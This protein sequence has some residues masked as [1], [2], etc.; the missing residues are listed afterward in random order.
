MKD[1][2][3]TL[4]RRSPPTDPRKEL[5]YYGRAACEALFRSRPDDIIRVYLE[6]A[7]IPHFSPLLKW[8]AAQRKAYHVV[9][10]EDLERLTESVHHQGICILARE[11]TPISF[12]ELEKRMKQSPA[13]GRLLAYL[14]GVENPHN[15]GAIVRT[16][17]HFGVRYVLG[18]RGRLPR[19]S[20]SACRVAE[21]GAEHVELVVLD[22][23]LADLARLQKSGHRLLATAVKHGRSLYEYRFTERA[24]IAFGAEVEGISDAMVKAADEVL[25]IPGSGM[26][27]SLNVGVAFAVIAGEYYRQ[28][29]VPAQ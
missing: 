20:P 28:R 6:Q 4:S 16:C 9:S 12:G 17:A 25:C 23:P 26:V 27:E 8:A 5:K 1:R 15:L 18:A 3:P 13:Q 22:S 7:L 21:G 10:A 24:I 29:V 2:K 19:L 11:R 14:D